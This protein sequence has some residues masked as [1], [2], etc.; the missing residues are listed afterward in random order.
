MPRAL[1]VYPEF[2]ETFWG[3]Q[4][5]LR[6]L[7][8]GA[9][10]P[11]LGL[12]TVAGLLSDD[13]ELELVD[14]NVRSLDPRRLEGADVVLTGGMMIQRPSVERVV[15]DC[16]DRGVPVVVGGPDATSSAEDLPREAHLVR[17]EAESPRLVEALHEMIGAG[18]RRVLDLR[19]ESTPLDESPLPRYDLIEFDDYVSM[20]LQ[21]SRGC[22]FKC[23][24]C[25]I[26]TL[27]GRTTRYKSV[28]RTLA[29]L[30]LL[31]E[32]GWRSGVFW[33]DDNFIGNKRDVKR[34]LPAV[35][36]WQRERDLPFQFYTQASVN[37]AS[38]AEL[39]RMMSVSGFDNVFLGIETPVDESLRE[40]KKLQNVRFD[41]E[42]SVATIQ[43]A[44]MEVMAGFI[45]GFDNDPDDI[46]ERLVSF[47]QS[48]GI[49]VAMTGLL[50]AIPGSPLWDRLEAEGRLLPTD[51]ARGGNNTFEFAFNFETR[52]D[53]GMLIRA[54]RRVLAEV[55]GKPRNYFHRVETLYERMRGIRLAAPPFSLKRMKA[56][57]R[58]FLAV[59]WSRYGWSYGRFLART[60]LRYPR[61]FQDAVRKGIVGFHFHQLTRERLAA[62]DF[63]RFLSS[64]VD[65]VRD[66]YAH[67]RREGR[68]VAGQVI[69]EA[70]RRL[71]GL[72]AAV[73]RETRARVEELEARLGALASGADP[74]SGLAR[75]RD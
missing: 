61:R 12:L 22:P 3:Y 74:A 25:D 20:A 33:V 64:A 47:I 36:E 6:F 46:D 27:F 59:P 34:I 18:E 28:E 72:P 49:P 53:P 4:R 16:V 48:S 10:H 41:L 40:T 15:A 23:E 21:M 7:G 2:P 67:G 35:A 50:T 44:G 66:A 51:A 29:E 30:D 19:E 38:D 8:G 68:R 70:R 69:A 57:L 31:Y 58:S 17:G 56:A 71:A 24:F 43:R 42:E 32:S 45:I 65:R 14:L 39:L 26:P 1:L 73:R 5:A 62:D 52:Q 60:L 63:Q 11:P 75:A 37:L 55:Y 54:Y 9:T 13:F